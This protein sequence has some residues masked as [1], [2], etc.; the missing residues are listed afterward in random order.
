[1]KFFD[2]ISL[3]FKNFLR[4]KVR[5]FL[6]ILGVTIGTAAVV[7]MLSLGIGMSEGFE[8]QMEM[9]GSLTTIEVNRYY[10]E[11]SPRGGRSEP[12]TIDDKVID[13]ISQIKGVKVVTPVMWHSAKLVSGKYI[14]WAQLYGIRPEALEALG[15]TAAQGRL[16]NPGEHD[17]LLFGAGATQNFYNPKTSRWGNPG[18]RPPVNVM[19]DRLELTLDQSYGESYS[20]PNK[21]PAKLYKVRTAGVLEPTNDQYDW[22][23]VVDI[24]YLQKIVRE[25]NISQGTFSPGGNSYEQAL[26]KVENVN[27]VEHV[28]EEIKAMKLGTFSLQ[29]I[30]KGMKEQLFMIQAVLGGI[31][32]VSLLVAALGITNTMVMSIYERTREIGVMKV[33]GCLL[34]DIRK[35]FLWEAGIIGF[36][37]GVIGLLLS[38]SASFLL[39]RFGGDLGGLLGGGG[40]APDGTRLPISVIPVWLAVSAVGFA[41][42]VGLVSGFYPANRA[43]K[44]SALEAIRNE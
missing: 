1:M 8:K 5:S 6:T 12:A 30:L 44:L 20:D 38:L 29:D 14:A 26:V 37:G 28:L 42:L 35:L 27:Q 7:V 21:K 17:M 32:A 10:Y 18:G 40:Y 41:T 31:G 19:T 15:Y 22:S 25:Y 11:E 39:N 3:A 16:L 33:L 9:M 4:R 34:T 36:S 43:M 13:A 24:G 23:V 2:L